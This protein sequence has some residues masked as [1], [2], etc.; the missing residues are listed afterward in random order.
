[1]PRWTYCTLLSLLLLYPAVFAQKS[2]RKPVASVHSAAANSTALPSEATIT[3]FIRHMFGYDSSLTWKVQSIKRARDPALSEVSV[4]MS[5]TQGQQLLNF[6]VTPN[7]HYAIVGEGNMIPFGA[8]PFAPAL[9][10]LER[11][12]KGPARGPANSPVTIVE[13]SDLQCPHCKAA[14]PTIEKLLAA[15][16]N[17]R[18]IFENF[19]LASH[20]WAFKGAAFDDCIGRRNN[21]AFWKFVKAVY[22]GQENITEAT[23]DEKLLNLANTAGVNGKEIATCAAEPQTRTRVEQSVQLGNSLGVTGTPTLFINGRQISN[24]SGIP[25]EALKAI[26]EYQAK[27]G[28]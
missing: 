23:A 3:E 28:K 18:F 25:F 10:E 13:F 16:P 27:Q 2:T 1:M 14:Q 20:N 5:S 19:P 4:L 22:D 17:A 21:D 7:Q 8:D 24:L 15:E 11:G 12:A 26:V 9:A 6:F